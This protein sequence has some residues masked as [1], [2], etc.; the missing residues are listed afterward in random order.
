MR[1]LRCLPLLI[2]GTLFASPALAQNS[3]ERPRV[4][5][6]ATVAGARSPVTV[7]SCCEPRT[8]P[9]YAAIDDTVST[10]SFGPAVRLNWG[11]RAFSAASVDWKH[12][13]R[14]ERDLPLPSVPPSPSIPG[15]LANAVIG[16]TTVREGWS[17]AIGQG[18]DAVRGR[19]WR[20][21]VSVALLVDH[22]KES[23]EQ[24]SLVYA[25]PPHEQQFSSSRRE[26]L[27]A[28]AAG[29][30]LTAFLAPRAFVTAGVSVRRYLSTPSIERANVGVRIGVGIALGR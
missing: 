27:A 11:R 5:V 18:L 26:T 2:T 10:W 3:P 30:T 4:E 23:Y 29:G 19:R 21:S 24:Q 8:P 17:V 20:A 16:Q 15:G 14:H 13:A 1:V 22:V 25:D 7:V 6:A 12:R 28:G 9:R